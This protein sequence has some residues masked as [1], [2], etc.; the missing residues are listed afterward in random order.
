MIRFPIDLPEWFAV[1]E[2]IA[3]E[4]GLSGREAL[5]WCGG[6]IDMMVCM[7]RAWNDNL[8]RNGW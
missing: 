2:K 8:Y 6:Q 3:A 5:D 4:K 7:W 1:L